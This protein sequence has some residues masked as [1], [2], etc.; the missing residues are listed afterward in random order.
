MGC[1]YIGHQQCGD[2]PLLMIPGAPSLHAS[3][4]TAPACRWGGCREGV[5][6][7]VLRWVPNMSVIPLAWLTPSRP[8][9]Q[10]VRTSLTIGPASRHMFWAGL[11][12]SWHVPC[13]WQCT[14]KEVGVGGPHLQSCLQGLRP[15]GITAGS[16]QYFNTCSFLCTTFP[17]SCLWMG[18]GGISPLPLLGSGLA[19]PVPGSVLL[20]GRPPHLPI[21]GSTLLQPCCCR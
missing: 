3:S 18:A 20:L 21:Q 9:W 14:H 6:S 16:C 7:L 17:G 2:S 11:F 12:H 4:C 1:P 15:A 8:H 10:V 19:A 5:R 13:L